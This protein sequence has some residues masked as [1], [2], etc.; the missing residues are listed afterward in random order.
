M[1]G[2][3][4][5]T[6]TVTDQ[7][8]D[9]KRLHAIGTLAVTGG[10]DYA[11]GGLVASFAG[12]LRGSSR[13]PLTGAM[14]VYGI[15]GFIYAFVPGTT[16]ANGKVMIFCETTVA[17]NAPLLEHTVTALVAGVSADTIAFRCVFP[18]GR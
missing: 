13:P 14:V 8:F 9:G 6:P 11:A 4:T 3:A 2:T 16:Q 18:F 7:W 15:A 1:A 17:T 5:L 10:T 12:L